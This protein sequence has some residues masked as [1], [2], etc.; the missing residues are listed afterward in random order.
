MGEANILEPWESVQ[1]ERRLQPCP[2]KTERVSREHHQRA[3]GETRG[4]R[5]RVRHSLPVYTRDAFGE[6][7]PASET[8]D[9]P[10]GV[11][12]ADSRLPPGQ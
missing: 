7:H 12:V 2:E 5:Q 6:A 1:T 11:G 9:R 4:H 10:K 3:E 8:A